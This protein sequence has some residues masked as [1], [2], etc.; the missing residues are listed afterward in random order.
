[1]PVMLERDALHSAA[2]TLPP[3]IDVNTTDACTAE[4]NEQRKSKPT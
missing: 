4:G 2:A 3:A 1:M